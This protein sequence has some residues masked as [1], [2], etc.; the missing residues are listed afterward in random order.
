VDP[1]VPVRI[2]CSVYATIDKTHEAEFTESLGTKQFR[3]KES[4][5]TVL[6]RADYDTIQEP[7]LATLKRQIK[8]A[9]AQVL[10]PQKTLVQS[11]VIPDFVGREM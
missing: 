9:T 4:I 11:I 3:V 5:V 10:G 8:E 1:G 6:R 2:E 7:T